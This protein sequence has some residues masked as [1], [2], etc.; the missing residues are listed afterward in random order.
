M[1][2]VRETEHVI[3][4]RRITVDKGYGRKSIWVNKILDMFSKY[5]EGEWKRSRNGINNSQ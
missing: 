4:K 5:S 1:E 3:T 2:G